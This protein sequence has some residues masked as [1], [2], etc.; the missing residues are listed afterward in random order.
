M[1]FT[2]QLVTD[3]KKRTEVEQLGFDKML[4]TTYLNNE[5]W[6]D[7]IVEKTIEEKLLKLPA[8]NEK[9]WS[10]AKEHGLPNP[11]SGEDFFTYRARLNTHIQ[12][13][14]IFKR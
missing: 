3:I 1:C 9:L 7:S 14:S 4:P 2:E 6:N 11:A 5:R 8:E 10:F 12:E 13:N